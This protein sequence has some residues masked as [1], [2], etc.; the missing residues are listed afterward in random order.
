M[1][2][3]ITMEDQLAMAQATHGVPVTA[4]RIPVNADKDLLARYAALQARMEHFK[5]ESKNQA[6][7]IRTTWVHESYQLD[8]F[9]EIGLQQAANNRRLDLDS[10]CRNIRYKMR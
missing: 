5:K 10:Q 1:S 8:M 2:D 9:S 3:Q 4:K 7:Y 6:S